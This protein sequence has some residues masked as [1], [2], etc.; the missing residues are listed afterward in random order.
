MA[1]R[2]ALSARSSASRAATAS[3]LPAASLES[4]A[5]IAAL[6]SAPYANSAHSP[7]RYLP[8]STARARLPPVSPVDDSNGDRP[9]AVSE[10]SAH[11]RLHASHAAPSTITSLGQ[12]QSSG[13]LNG[14]VL[15]RSASSW[16]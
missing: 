12:S 16:T 8:L 3:G 4:I 14:A 7:H 15:S 5:S 11:P 1:P 6:V 10:K 2:S 13:A 9:P